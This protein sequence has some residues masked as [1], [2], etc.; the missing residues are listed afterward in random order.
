MSDGV[1]PENSQISIAHLLAPH[2]NNHNTALVIQNTSWT[3][4]ELLQHVQRTV[5]TLKD[6]SIKRLGIL[7]SRSLEAYVG[8]ISAHWLGIAYVPLNPTLPIDRLRD[9]QQQ[10]GLDALLIDDARLML[11]HQLASPVTT[12][13]LC[14]ESR[15]SEHYFPLVQP[16]MKNL[17]YLMFTSGSTGKPKGVP[18]SFD[19]LHSF[20][21]V[22]MR[23]YQLTS[24]DRVSQFSDL[25]FDVSIFD[26]VL[27]FGSGATLYVVPEATRL[28]PGRFIQEKQL[29]VWLS[30]PSTISIMQKLN[31]L[32]PGIYP[33]LKYSLFTG[34]AL[35]TSQAKAWKAAASNSQIENL[36]GPTEATIDCL[37][38]VFNNQVGY[39]NFVPIGQ[40]FPEVYAALINEE[41]K[42]LSA[43][44]EGEL[45][46]AGQQIVSG[47]WNDPEQSREKFVEL[48]HTKWGKK[49]WYLTGDF[50]VQDLNNN[51][52][53][54]GRRDNQCKILGQ[55]IELEE[56]E[57]HLREITRLT[58][59]AAVLLTAESKI[60]G[61]V[62]R[63]IHDLPSIQAQLK[64]RLPSYMLPEKIIVMNSFPYNSNLKL[65]RRLLAE[66][67]AKELS[68]GHSS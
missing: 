29:S 66:R 39:R 19:N 23:R 24:R 31:M 68:S 15:V 3:Y 65:D 38:Y 2:I 50:C 16:D 12:I 63:H 20:I 45:V 51:F 21:Q 60:I 47:Y 40:P 64:L 11:A 28:A 30:V 14:P 6:N 10:S 48:T 32:Q 59:V 49:M 22:I 43:G 4:A 17:A 34:E 18:V 56:I 1:Y 62:T 5:L 44:E 36:Y 13:T 58:E 61:V 37:G 27:A 41:Q 33:S 46:I 42:F 7:A 52:N 54:V 35:T 26:M 55:R 25:S 67:V 53:F 8:V 9:I 57:Y